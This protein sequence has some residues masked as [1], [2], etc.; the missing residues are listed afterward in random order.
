MTPDP[1]TG[2]LLCSQVAIFGDNAVNTELLFRREIS[3]LFVVSLQN[4]S[5]PPVVSR[6]LDFPN[7]IKRHSI[8]RRNW[9]KVLAT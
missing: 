4:S 2:K 7:S 5:D 8:W 1:G 3:A 6:P 9:I